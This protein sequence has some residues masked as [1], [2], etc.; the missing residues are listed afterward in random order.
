MNDFQ[1]WPKFLDPPYPVSTMHPSVDIYL[2]YR[3]WITNLIY[4]SIYDTHFNGFNLNYCLKWKKWKGLFSK[5]SFFHFVIR[6]FGCTL[7]PEYLPTST[8][9][10]FYLRTFCSIVILKT[11]GLISMMF[12]KILIILFPFYILKRK[13][14]F[15]KIWSCKFSRNKNLVIL[16][17]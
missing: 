9:N 8:L 5:I 16:V 17:L 4:T 11:V 3:L 14:F 7:F 2:H 1:K 15:F 12:W 6:L 13:V 10:I